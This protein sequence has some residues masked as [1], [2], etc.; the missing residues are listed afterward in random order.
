ME[1]LAKYGRS[2]AT[3]EEYT[4]RFKIF[5]ENMEKIMG[6]NEFK[7]EVEGIRL[8]INR[9]TDWTKYEYQ[10]LLGFK[11]KNNNNTITED[12]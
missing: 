4:F 2:Y 7:S 1:F 3:K 8:T 6:F 10:R 12:L 5:I 9:Y 11:A